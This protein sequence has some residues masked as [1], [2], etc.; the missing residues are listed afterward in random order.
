MAEKFPWR[1]IILDFEIKFIYG[2]L[3]TQNLRDFKQY[4]NKKYLLM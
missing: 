2:S 1:T 3:A 4:G